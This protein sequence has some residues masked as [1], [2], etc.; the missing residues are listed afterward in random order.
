MNKTRLNETRDAAVRHGQS[1]LSL[2]ELLVAMV[3]GVVLVGGAGY[4]YVQSRNSFGTNETVSRLQE[5]ARYAMSV[6]E[7]DVRMAGFWGLMNDA[8]LVIG[9]ATPAEAASGLLASHICG[10]NYAFDLFNTVQGTDAGYPLA[11]APPGGAV[12]PNTDALTVRRASAADVPAAAGK[13]QVY[14]SR[15]LARLFTGGAGGLPGPVGPGSGAQVNDLVVHTYYVSR[16]SDNRP[17]LPS[18]RLRQLLNNGY[19]EQEIVTGVE[20]M[21]VQIGVDTAGT[22]GEATRYI[23]P[24]APMP[25][26][27]Q[28][29]SV[30]L[31][32]LVRSDTPE[33]GHADGRD[34][35]MGNRV[36]S[37]RDGFRRVLITRTIQLRNSIG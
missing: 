19:D 31:W 37:P 4:V 9:R 33:V 30:R 16:N 29:V 7:P 6:I 27:A 23:D 5:T 35:T 25:L 36:Y 12:L 14:S 2:V 24:A 21:Q 22:S 34:Y 13:V 11:C 26:G 8:D 17:G 28:A 32:I 3:I 18:L 1:G 15:T 20:D 10:N